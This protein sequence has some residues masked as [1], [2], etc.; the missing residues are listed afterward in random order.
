MPSRNEIWM[1]DLGLAAKIRPCLIISI[2][3]GLQDRALVTV[4]PHTTTLRGSKFE[5][6]LKVTFLRPGAFVAQNIVTIPEAKLI[7]RLGVLT[8]LQ[9]SEVEA[10]I[11]VWL[12]L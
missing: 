7:R 11:K 4:V 8:A 3:A 2:P 6:A 1:V 10:A 5:I 12:G 9:V